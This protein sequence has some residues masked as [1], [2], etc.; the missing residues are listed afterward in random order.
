M[1]LIQNS[2]LLNS[3]SYKYSQYNQYPQGTEYVYSYIESR[4][5]QW[6]QTVFFGLQ[7]FLKEYLTTP[8]TQEEIDIAE[9]IITAHG[10]PFYR[11]GWEYILKQ[12]NGYLPLRI[13]AVPEGTVV[14]VKNVRVTV[15][16]TDRNCWW[17]TSFVETALLRAV[18]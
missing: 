4:G 13:K 17:L 7:M 1:N 18:W 3:D 8:I 9:Q 14:P 11:E 16:N 10:E 2:I 5:G 12:H 6:N 15:E